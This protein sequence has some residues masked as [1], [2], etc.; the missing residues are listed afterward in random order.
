MVRLSDDRIQEWLNNHKA[1][2]TQSFDDLC[3]FCMEQLKALVRP[4]LRR[5][6]LVQTQE[7]TTDITIETFLRLKKSLPEVFPATV[8]EFYWFLAELIRRVLLDHVKSIRRH[9]AIRNGGDWDFQRAEQTDHPIDS[10]L[11]NAFHEYVS[12]LPAAEQKLFDLLYY[13]GLSIPKTAELL[14]MAPSTL[15]RRWFDARYRMQIR[16]GLISDNF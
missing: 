12:A 9:A 16:L 6:P 15:K 11:M 4:R 2:R 5:F 3:Q 14:D 8:T 1:G 7:Q 10:E 13:C